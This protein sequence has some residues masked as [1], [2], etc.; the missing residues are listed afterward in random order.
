M[1][2]RYL[3]DAHVPMRTATELFCLDLLKDFD[4]DSLAAL[5]SP[6]KIETVTYVK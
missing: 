6:A 4:L 1:S 5:A 2:L 3:V